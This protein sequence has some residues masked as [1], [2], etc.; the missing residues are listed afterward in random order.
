MR[1][2][3]SLGGDE[4]FSDSQPGWKPCDGVLLSFEPAPGVDAW[5]GHTR[6]KLDSDSGAGI[7]VGDRPA[8]G[9]S[10]TWETV[11]ADGGKHGPSL[12]WQFDQRNTGT[13]SELM[14]ALLIMILMRFL[15]GRLRYRTLIAVRC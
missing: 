12:G 13:L 6:T 15:V 5:G 9:L 1:L 10:L 3:R 8:L 4:G 14:P 2:S 11:Q 7:T